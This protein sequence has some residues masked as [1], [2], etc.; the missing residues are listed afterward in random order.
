[1]D[2]G[3]MKRQ[4]GKNSFRS[5]LAFMR[6]ELLFPLSTLHRGL[7][8]NS[9]GAAGVKGVRAV[10][11][12]GEVASGPV[13]AAVALSGPVSAAAALLVK[14]SAAAALLLDQAWKC[15]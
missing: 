1:M 7:K 12:S 8:L 3:K 6:S 2:A 13:S 10:I 11:R 9:P 4:G 15:G 14:A 5:L